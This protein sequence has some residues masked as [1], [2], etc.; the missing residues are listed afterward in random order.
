MIPDILYLIGGSFLN[1]LA[2]VLQALGFIPPIGAL[3]SSVDYVLSFTGYFYGVLDIPRIYIDAGI[4]IGF[5]FFW[6]AFLLVWYVFGF[7][8]SLLARGSSQH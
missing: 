6:F 4:V 1:A 8:R 2:F 3:F 7:F 5:E